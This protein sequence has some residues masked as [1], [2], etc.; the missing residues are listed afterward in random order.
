MDVYVRHFLVQETGKEID[1]IFEDDVIVCGFH[2]L[3]YMTQGK[4]LKTLMK[5]GTRSLYENY[6]RKSIK[7]KNGYEISQLRSRK[8]SD[9][10]RLSHQEHTK[11]E[12]ENILQQTTK[13]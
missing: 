1:T 3:G 7:M 13:A 9:S 6:K 4:M 10:L 5:I 12:K 11:H 8:K 2:K